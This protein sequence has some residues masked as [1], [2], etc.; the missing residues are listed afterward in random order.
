MQHEADRGGV[1]RRVV[2]IGA[3]I[4]GTL[5]ALRLLHDGHRV[6]LVDPDLPGSGASSGNAGCLSPSS[7]VPLAG[8]GTLAKVPGWLLDPAGPLAIRPAYLLR[9]APWLLRLIRAGRADRVDAQARALHGLIGPCLHLLVPWL[10]EIGAGGLVRSTGSLVVYRSEASW[11]ADQ[12]GRDLRRELGI[13]FQE[14]ARDG[15]LALDPALGPAA[16]RGLH[17]PENGHVLDPQRLVEALAEAFVRQGGEIVRTGARDFAIEA[18]RLT[19]VVTQGGTLKADA[20]V[21]AAGAFS[22]PLA[23]AAGEIVPLESERGYHAMLS[24][25]KGPHWPTVDATA[26]IVATPMQTGVRLTGT[27]EFAGL[28][29]PPDWRRAQALLGLGR[30]LYPGLADGTAPVSLWMG[31]RPS[32]PDS[33]PAIGRAS[34]CRDIVLAFGHGHL[35]LTAAPKTAEVVTDLLA[36]RSPALDLAPFAPG[37]FRWSRLGL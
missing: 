14:L 31:H 27:V 12:A 35:G 3:G 23:R 33:L 29:A 10:Q 22:A 30:Q 28:R 32:L 9:L 4:V 2:V 11:A 26:K 18:G 24:G 17:F 1:G 16:F 8:P 21:I 6:T 13:P 5:S 34:R 15:L 19:G 36:G 25:A 20:A 37:R 7:V